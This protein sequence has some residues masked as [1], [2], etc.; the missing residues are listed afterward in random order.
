MTIKVLAR[1]KKKKKKN[2]L[3]IYQMLFEAVMRLLKILRLSL[4]TF[5]AFRNEKEI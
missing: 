3:D 2:F 4:I 1:Q 5:S